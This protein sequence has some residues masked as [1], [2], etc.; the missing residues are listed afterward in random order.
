MRNATDGSREARR[1]GT[2]LGPTVSDPIFSTAPD[3]SSPNTFTMPT[4]QV[5]YDGWLALPDTAR[6]KLGVG[7]GDR[8]EVEIADGAVVLRP[9]RRA[10]AAGQAVP[11]PAVAT[12][13]PAEAASAVTPPPTVKRGPGRPR[14]ASADAALPPGPNKARGRAKVSTLPSRSRADPRP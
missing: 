5:H 3:P 6:R 4:I 2:V 9:A 7:T 1:L 10:D 11:E 14:K 13:Q 12:E 8:L